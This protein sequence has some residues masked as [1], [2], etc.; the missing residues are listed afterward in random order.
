MFGRRKLPVV[1]QAEATE[2]GL[3]CLTM[4]ARYWGH[5]VDL[6]VLRQRFLISL[7]G[8]SLKS[9]MAIAGTLKLGTRALRLD[10]DHLSQLQCPAI[11]HWDLNHFVVLKAVKNGKA[12]I[13]DP[14]IGLRV[15]PLSKVS[16]HFTGIALE[17]TPTAEFSPIEARLR[18]HLSLLWH[19]LVGLKRALFQTLTLSIILQIIVLMMPFYLQLVVDGVLPNGDYQLLWGL[20]IG[21]TGLVIIRAVTE[22]T[23]GWAILVYGNQMS[24]QMV[25]NVFRHL[26]RLPAAYFEKRHVGDVIS[27]MNSTTPI[28]E[29]LTQSVVAILLDG[30]MAVLMLIVMYLYSPLLAT[31]VFATVVLLVVTTLLIYPHLRRTQEEAIYTKAFENTHV[32]ESIRASTTVKLFGREA[33]REAAWRNLYTDVVNANVSH[34]KFLIAQKF[35]QTL[36]TGLQI[37]I[38]VFMA[39]QIMMTPDSTFTLGMLVAFLAYRQQFTDSLTQLLEKGIEFRLLGLHLERLSDIIFAQTENLAEATA[40]KLEFKGEIS[41]VDVSFKYSPMDPFVVKQQS[42]HIPAGS[43]TTLTGRS[44]GG[45]T[46][47]MKLI[48]GL[49]APTKG[50]IR[51]DGRPLTDIG[52]RNW[53]QH[54]GVVMQDDRLLSG[55]IADNISFFDPAVDMDKVYKAAQSAK[56]H[57]EI[58][59][60]PGD[61]TSMVG[62]MGSILSGGQK[63]RVLLARALYHDP[64][65]LFLDEGTANLDVETE[66]QIVEVISQ[67]DITRIIVAHRPA[68]LETSDQVIVVGNS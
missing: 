10:M 35:A 54:I 39:A 37:V 23:R 49:Y 33:Q 40:E 52:I 15:M 29:A 19:R 63:Q 2:C 20:V 21:F 67:M 53:R 46:T 45:K 25:G 3:A 34:G 51:I 36:I 1:L 27:R 50:E 43:M 61:Y 24:A 26:I 66:K 13:I 31:I 5:D 56:I 57:D 42:I 11:L 6:N 16:Q 58:M 47:I 62:D 28:Q 64:K 59:A 38:V 17:L 41:L 9:V 68:F 7:K 65:V 12:H 60:I 44:G 30:V 18:P 14:A 4:V 48:L 8:A 55:T 32:I 22:A